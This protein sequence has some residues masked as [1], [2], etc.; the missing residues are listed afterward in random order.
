[1]FQPKWF[2]LTPVGQLLV[3]VLET[4]FLSFVMGMLFIKANDHSWQESGTW[5]R[6]QARHQV[7][8]TWNSEDKEMRG[9][10]AES[11]GTGQNGWHRVNQSGRSWLSSSRKELQHPNVLLFG[12][13]VSSRLIHLYL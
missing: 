12:C 4:G 1:L 9:Q 6:T 5:T 8:V 11:R 13:R 3:A 10:A 2:Q 7:L